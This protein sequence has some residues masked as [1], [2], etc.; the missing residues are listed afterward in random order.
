MPS[1]HPSIG[2]KIRYHRKQRGWALR[3]LEARTGFPFS[4]I[5][6]WE[7]HL[8]DPDFGQTAK[9]A[10]AFGIPPEWLWDLSPAPKTT[11]SVQKKST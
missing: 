7:R 8:A 5:S 4:L 10:E 9:L 3:E 11:P 6:R 2:R 1:S